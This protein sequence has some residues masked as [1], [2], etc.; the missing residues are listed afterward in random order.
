MAGRG[1]ALV[2]IALLIFKTLYTINAVMK[3][4]VKSLG[5][6]TREK[7][8]INGILLRRLCLHKHCRRMVYTAPWSDPNWSEMVIGHIANKVNNEK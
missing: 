8:V 1:S 3:P 5:R 7:H 4:P 2:S 6:N